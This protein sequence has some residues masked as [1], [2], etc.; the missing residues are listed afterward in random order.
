MRRPFFVC[1]LA[2]E[3]G[4]MR[5]SSPEGTIQTTLTCRRRLPCRLIPASL[6]PIHRLFAHLLRAKS[7]IAFSAPK[8]RWLPDKAIKIYTGNM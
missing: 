5:L 3:M 1:A 4:K 8:A 6:W 2:K 7:T